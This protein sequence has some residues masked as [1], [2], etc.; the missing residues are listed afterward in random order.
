MFGSSFTLL[1][2][3]V[4]I[5]TLMMKKLV[6]KAQMSLIHQFSCKWFPFLLQYN[7][8]IE[9][10]TWNYPSPQNARF[11]QQTFIENVLFWVE[12]THIRPQRNHG[13]GGRSYAPGGIWPVYRM[14]GSPTP[15]PCT[16]EPHKRSGLMI[17]SATVFV[18]FGHFQMWLRKGFF[19]IHCT[20]EL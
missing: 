2:T 15:A 16:A 10:N 8:I 5:P 9:K 1:L 20:N 13:A 11:I 12:T 6:S 7:K 18:V 14:P 17:L 4:I 3:G 19:P